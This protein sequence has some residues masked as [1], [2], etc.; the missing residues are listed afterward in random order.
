MKVFLKIIQLLV[1]VC[2][3]SCDQTT[4]NYQQN[5]KVANEKGMLNDSLG[6]YFSTF[7]PIDS[8]QYEF[9]R[10]TF[11][12]KYLSTNLYAFKEPVLYN[13][14]LGMEQYRFLWLRSFH[15]PMIFTIA[16]AKGDI[17]LTTKKLDR[18]PL[19]QDKLY[20]DMPDRDSYYI[21]QGYQLIKKIDTVE[22]GKTEIVTT[23]K[24]DRKAN[25]IYDSTK[26]LTK[27]DWSYFLKLLNEAKFWNLKPYEWAGNN[28]GA[29]WTIEANT[30]KGYKYL[31][32]QSPSGKIRKMGELLITLSGLK[33]EIY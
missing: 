11:W 22:K 33:E 25:I 2:F 1:L 19:F 20:V 9:V 18:Q 15:L 14:Y 12:Q 23:V 6:F 3:L 30:R 13:D 7:E 5:R 17:T 24:A 31:V 16:N 4:Y 29:V 21:A 27:E 32:R 8:S 28:D 26:T 10:D